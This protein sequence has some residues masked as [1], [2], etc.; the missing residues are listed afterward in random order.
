M[1]R[2]KGLKVWRLWIQ[3]QSTPKY[4]VIGGIRTKTLAPS[5]LRVFFMTR[6]IRVADRTRKKYRFLCDIPMPKWGTMK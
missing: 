3:E 6:T 4:M 5:H 2:F 1:P